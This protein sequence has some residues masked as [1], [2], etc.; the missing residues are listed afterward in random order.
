[1]FSV[2]GVPS[3]DEVQ[4][5]I[6]MRGC[7]VTGGN[8]ALHKVLLRSLN[9]GVLRNLIMYSLQKCTQYHTGSMQC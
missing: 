2:V 7:A 5:D 8:C 9:G 6:E 4:R 3:F 1:M